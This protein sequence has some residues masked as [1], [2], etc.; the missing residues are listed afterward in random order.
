MQKEIFV[1]FSYYFFCAYISDPHL[2]CAIPELCYL[3]SLPVTV[4]VETTGKCAAMRSVF[5]LIQLYDSS[6]VEVTIWWIS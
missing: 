4:W 2:Y 6:W 1:D 5:D 3:F